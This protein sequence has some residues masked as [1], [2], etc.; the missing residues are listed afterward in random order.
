MKPVILAKFTRTRRGGH[1]KG[2]SFGVKTYSLKFTVA[3]TYKYFCIPHEL[4]GMVGQITV[5]S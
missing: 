3:G 4:L 2:G 5:V 1:K